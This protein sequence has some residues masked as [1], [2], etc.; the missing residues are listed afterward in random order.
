[1]FQCGKQCLR[2]ERLTQTRAVSSFEVICHLRIP[3]HFDDRCAIGISD[4][5]N[6]G[7]STVPKN[8]AQKDRIDMRGPQECERLLHRM[9]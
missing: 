9:R 4:A 2:S 8:T 5:S 1:M 3:G 6:V 7:S